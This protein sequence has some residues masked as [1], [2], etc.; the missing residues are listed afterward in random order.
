MSL[1]KDYEN[2]QKGLISIQNEKDAMQKL[3][4]TV[5]KDYEVKIQK[6]MDEKY[7]AVKEVKRNIEEKEVVLNVQKVSYEGTITTV[8]RIRELMGI[9]MAH[10]VVSAPEVYTYSDRDEQGNYLGFNNKRKVPI[11][12][13]Q[14]IKDDGYSIFNIYI[15]SNKKPTNKYSL[16]VRGYSIFGDLL[17]GHTF[18]HIS[19]VNESSCNFYITIKDAPTQKDLL[20]YVEKYM[21]KI[22]KALPS[23]YDTIVKEYQEAEKFLEEKEWQIFYWEGQKHYYE[24]HYSGGTETDEYKEVLKKLKELRSK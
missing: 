21:S 13:I 11:D 5:E 19:G 14:T 15:V 22:L 12:P 9:I 4:D 3:G 7:E 10:K 2:A 23:F 16:I 24:E 8:N 6:L 20:T 1:L 18:G 17:R